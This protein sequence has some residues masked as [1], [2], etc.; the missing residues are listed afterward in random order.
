MSHR[1]I[2]ILFICAFILPGVQARRVTPDE[3][4]VIAEEVLGSPAGVESIGSRSGS[5][6]YRF[7][8]RA[9]GRGFA[10][11]SADTRIPRVLG[12]S[13]TGHH[14]FSN[15]PP[16]LDSL[17]NRLEE[18]VAVMDINGPDDASWSVTASRTAEGE[19]VELK[20]AEWNQ[21]EPYNK[22]FPVIDGS[23]V[24][25]G[26]GGVANAIVMRYH[27]YPSKGRGKIHYYT[28]SEQRYSIDLGKT[29]FDYDKMPLVVDETTTEEQKS[30]IA[31][32]MY[33]SSLAL[34]SSFNKDLTTNVSGTESLPLTFFFGY[35]PECQFIYKDDLTDEEFLN[36]TLS[37]IDA[38]LPV[39]YS[40][41][42]LDINSGHS[43]VVDGYDA[44]RT[45]VHCNFGWGGN[46]NGFYPLTDLMGRYYCDG[47]M[48]NIKPESDSPRYTSNAKACDTHMNGKG[49]IRISTADIKPGE[50][51]FYFVHDV[52][53]NNFAVTDP[54]DQ[55]LLA[56]CIVDGDGKPLEIIASQR[57]YYVTQEDN[58]RSPFFTF[59]MSGAAE[60]KLDEI[61][62]EYKL[63]LMYK[64][65]VA[66][67]SVWKEIA[68]TPFKPTS[69]PVTGNDPLPGCKI[70]IDKDSNISA[71]V[72][73][74]MDN[75]QVTLTSDRFETML[76]NSSSM[77]MN[78]TVEQPIDGYGLIYDVN[79]RTR[80]SYLGRSI[81][82][83]LEVNDYQR[84][85]LGFQLYRADT[86]E[87]T[88]RVR[89]VKLEKPLTL[90]VS[91][92]GTLRELVDARTARLT[93]SLTIL[94]QIDARDIYHIGDAFQVV[95]KLDLSKAKI[96]PV[97]VDQWGWYES[98]HQPL[99]LSQ[100]A[101]AIPPIGLTEMGRLTDIRLPETLERLG[102][103]SLSR[104]N[105]SH[106]EGYTYCRGSLTLPASVR[107][108]DE[109]AINCKVDTIISL[110]TVPPKV[111]DNTFQDP[112]W[113]ILCVPAGSVDSYRSTPVWNRFKEILPLDE[114]AG[115]GSIGDSGV[116]SDPV[117]ELYD[118]RGIKVAEG[119]RS[120]LTHIASGIYLERVKATGKV[121][122]RYISR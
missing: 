46:L 14:D 113:R 103:H 69:I 96:M 87:V 88:L 36:L 85:E 97:T 121:S 91:E 13:L 80:S 78:F 94:G 76:Y 81:P 89:Y 100:P 110:A 60:S 45:Q 38:G 98:H 33:A 92:P 102:A 10:I 31:M 24:P 29:S 99:S 20:T 53:T 62:P 28:D 104:L 59:W 5:N 67:G 32:L 17:L 72:W 73:S 93:P 15:L 82:I 95:E 64:S 112:S 122:R 6:L 79:G 44:T 55:P 90:Q 19:A 86:A 30:E 106:N 47:I 107:Q 42:P 101:N 1:L 63:A 43:W 66:E 54:I 57:M 56:L 21:G 26:C 108:L 3:S 7:Y 70:I 37:Q 119:R 74:Q 4:K 68:G 58:T 2:T 18:S 109:L 83:D 114:K 115:I 84:D 65:S 34:G 22:W 111:M 12:Y 35:S 120:A 71:S 8:K 75:G 9:D 16:Q 27:G 61:K 118:M 40:G 11:V 49:V 52:K 23:R 117:V 77:P 51:F 50:R 116:D 41:A 39:I 25:V 48:I 105:I